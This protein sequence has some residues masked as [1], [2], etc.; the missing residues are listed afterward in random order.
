LR[1]FFEGTVDSVRAIIQDI[2]PDQTKASPVPSDDGLWFD[3]DQSLA[4][5]RLEPAERNP[6]HSIL[7]SQSRAR[8]FPLQYAQLLTE[9]K[10]LKSETATGTGKSAEAVEELNHK[11]NHEQ[12]FYRRDMFQYL[13]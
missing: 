11:C 3:D 12:R 1:V 4:P 8:S 5:S 2:I 7:D 6:K 10:D 13:R 9:S